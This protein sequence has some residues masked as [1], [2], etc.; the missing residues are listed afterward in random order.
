MEEGAEFIPPE[1]SDHSSQT[2]AAINK[3]A[4]SKKPGGSGKFRGADFRK[5]ERQENKRHLTSPL[6]HRVAKSLLPLSNYRKKI[7]IKVMSAKGDKWS[8]EFK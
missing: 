8:Q 6:F 1:A 7:M 4:L 3:T 5:D 2:G